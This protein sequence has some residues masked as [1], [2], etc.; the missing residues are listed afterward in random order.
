VLKVISELCLYSQSKTPNRVENSVKAHG[1]VGNNL[2]PLLLPAHHSFIEQ[3]PQSFIHVTQLHFQFS[4]PF[5]LF[6]F[7]TSFLT[8]PLLET[9]GGALFGA[10]LQVLFHKLDSHQVLD[11]FRGKKL[12]EKLLKNLRRKLVSINA[13][14]DDAE[15]KQ[16]TNP[17]V[18]AWLDDVRDVLLDTEDLL[19]EIDY[20]FSKT[21]S[22]RQYQTSSSQVRMCEAERNPR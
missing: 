21:Q 12:D 10:V 14:V 5:L 19:D 6:H 20:E 11:Y 17:Y 3:N 1:A 18:I 22:Q 2:Q 8:M 15:L 4:E 16:F 9:L 7:P 13:V